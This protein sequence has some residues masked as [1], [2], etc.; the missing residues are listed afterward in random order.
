MAGVS[1]ELNGEKINFTDENGF[2]VNP[3]II[4]YMSSSL[5]SDTNL[6]QE[7]SNINNPE[8]RQEIAKNCE[9]RVK[10]HFF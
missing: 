3:Q 10:N 7:L 8:I 9:M 6:I 2:T 4:K 5:K 1:V